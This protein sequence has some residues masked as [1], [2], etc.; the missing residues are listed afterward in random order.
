MQR[1][2]VAPL[3]PEQRAAEAM[4]RAAVQWGKLEMPEQGAKGPQ[5]QREPRRGKQIEPC[6][7]IPR[8]APSNAGTTLQE[9]RQWGY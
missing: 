5:E 2:E 9:A 3:S 4:A 6:S 1:V 7:G 8:Q